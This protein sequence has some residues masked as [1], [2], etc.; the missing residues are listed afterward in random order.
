MQIGNRNKNNV[1]NI[2]QWTKLNIPDIIKI[3]KDLEEF[4]N[5]N[6][7]LNSTEKAPGKKKED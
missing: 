4:A 5:V 2:S 3:A 1:R 6:K 7:L